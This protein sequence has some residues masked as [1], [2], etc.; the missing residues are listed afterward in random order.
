[1]KYDCISYDG[2]KIFDKFY[3]EVVNCNSLEEYLSCV[4]MNLLHSNT[5]YKKLCDEYDSITSSN[6][7]IA[8]VI[9]AEIP[10]ELS[11]D[12]CKL[13]YRLFELKRDMM[14][15]EDQAIFFKGQNEAYHYFKRINLIKEK[16]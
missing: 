2:D 7:K 15:I 10:V 9:D 6:R 12:E 16:N 13:L 3:Y 11:I 1:M 8:I 5:E 4:K 14:S